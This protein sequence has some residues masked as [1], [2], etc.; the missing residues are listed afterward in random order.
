MTVSLWVEIPL[1]C[2]WNWMF[3]TLWLSWTICKCRNEANILCVLL[4]L[5]C[6]DDRVEQCSMLPSLF[7]GF[8]VSDMIR[9]CTSWIPFFYSSKISFLVIICTILHARLW[10]RIKP[11]SFIL[12][13]YLCISKLWVFIDLVSHESFKFILTLL[14]TN[15]T[16]SRD[17]GCKLH[18]VDLFFTC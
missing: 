11:I 12:I 13:I 8:G 2:W 4:Q 17:Y 1:I 7:I 5:K 6:K 15:L 14:Q 10:Q 3:T 9:E 18:V 16:W